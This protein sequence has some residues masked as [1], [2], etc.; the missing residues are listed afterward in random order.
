MRNKIALLRL[1][2][3]LSLFVCLMKVFLVFAGAI[4]K[5]G[6]F[7]KYFRKQNNF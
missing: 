1:K 7:K 2:K 6:L 3:F 5:K 4:H